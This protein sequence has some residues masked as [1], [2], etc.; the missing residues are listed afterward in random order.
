MKRNGGLIK[1]ADD[2]SSITFND[3]NIAV[4]FIDDRKICII[5]T[6][7]GLKACTD[8]CPHAGGSLSE[9]YLDHHQNIVC[10]VHGYKF[11]LKTGRDAFNEGYFLK[12]FPVIVDDDGVFIQI[13]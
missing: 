13:Q 12:T 9:G 4:T 1:I 3:K 8:R 10:P 7:D 11:N 2:V 5:K 6:F